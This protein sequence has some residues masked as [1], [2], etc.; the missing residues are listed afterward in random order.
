MAAMGVAAVDPLELLKPRKAFF[1]PPAGGWYDTVGWE[2]FRAELLRGAGPPPVITEDLLQRA[3]DAAYRAT[4]PSWIQ[5][6]HRGYSDA[7]N[8]S[9]RGVDT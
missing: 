6:S 1:L 7:I 4:P 9:N 3:M 2:E 5:W 8:S